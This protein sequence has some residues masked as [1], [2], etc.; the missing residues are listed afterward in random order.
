LIKRGHHGQVNHILGNLVRLHYPGIVMKG[1]RAPDAGYGN[2][3]GVVGNVFSLSS[4]MF[5]KDQRR[6]PEGVEQEPIKIP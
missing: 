2:A 3:Q 1:A 4:Y 6:R 5:M